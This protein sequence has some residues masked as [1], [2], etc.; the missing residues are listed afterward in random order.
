M[1]KFIIV[2]RLLLPYYNLDFSDEKKCDPEKS[3]EY[4]GRVRTMAYIY[5]P[6][7]FRIFL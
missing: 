2:Y 4:N 7:I 3:K 1:S 5:I 6:D